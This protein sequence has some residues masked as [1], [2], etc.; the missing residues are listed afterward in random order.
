MDAIRANPEHKDADLLPVLE[1]SINDKWT[2]K[3]HALFVRAVK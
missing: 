1:E 2:K 3:E